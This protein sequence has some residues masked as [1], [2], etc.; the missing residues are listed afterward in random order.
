LIDT[1]QQLAVLAFSLVNPLPLRRLDMKAFISRIINFFYPP[2]RKIM[3]VQTFRYAFNGG[4]N[5]L[6]D[7]VIYFI[8]Y[9]FILKKAVLHLGNIAISAHIAA[10]L[11][12][13]CISFPTGFLLSKYITFEGSPMRG[14]VQLF[15]YGLVVAACIGLNYVFLKLFVEQCGIYPTIAKMIT[16]VFVVT[17]SY[18]AQKHFTFRQQK[19]TDERG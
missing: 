15:R 8:S 4:M 3:D 2:F 10:F 18:F 7:I 14:R 11:I 16:T 9:N 12:A 17:F 19:H 1:V 5:T 13:F 6:L